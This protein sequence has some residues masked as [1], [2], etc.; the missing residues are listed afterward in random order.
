V[1]VERVG[2]P[3]AFFVGGALCPDPSRDKPAPTLKPA[4]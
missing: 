1:R 2:D 3:N 4:R